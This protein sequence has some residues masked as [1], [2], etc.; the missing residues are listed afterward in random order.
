MKDFTDIIIAPV[1]TEKA[2]IQ[3][4]ANIYTFKVAKSANKIEIKKAIEEAFGV[5][6]VKV[7][8]ANTKAKDKR[9]GRYTGKTQTYKK[10][11]ITLADGEK[12]EI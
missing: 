6:V 12:I 1:I 11:Y 2:A 4:E 3:A 5:K 10:A 7:N 9:V 8:T